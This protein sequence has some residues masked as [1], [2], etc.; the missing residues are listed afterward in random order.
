MNTKYTKWFEET[1][2][3]P[4]RRRAAICALSKQRIILI[5]CALVTTAATIEMFFTAT[6]SPNSPALLT[7][8]SALIWMG[9]VRIDARRQVFTLLEKFGRDASCLKP[10]KSL[11]QIAIGAVHSY[12]AV[13]VMNAA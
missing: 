8:S 9:I 12:V 2:A 1:A 6:Y 7:I 10:I 11:E 5:C 3:D 13:N 4:I